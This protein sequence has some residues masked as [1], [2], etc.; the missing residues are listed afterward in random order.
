[1]E[2]LEELRRLILQEQQSAKQSTV[3]T[4]FVTFKCAAWPDPK[5][6][7]PSEDLTACSNGEACEGCLHR[8]DG[9]CVRGCWELPE[10]HCRAA[11]S[12]TTRQVLLA[13][14]CG[15]VAV[16]RLCRGRLLAGCAVQALVTISECTAS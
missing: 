11:G 5:L 9:R 12:L 6:Y 10:T 7:A 8:L 4:A 1:M 3:P 14:L 13:C 2:R 16:K 15:N